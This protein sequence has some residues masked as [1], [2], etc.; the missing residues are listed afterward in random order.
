MGTMSSSARVYN[1]LDQLTLRFND[2]FYTF[3]AEL[4]H[5]MAGKLLLFTR[6]GNGDELV[7]KIMFQPADIEERQ[8]LGVTCTKCC[9]RSTILHGGYVEVMDR[10]DGDLC[11]YIR[12]RTTG[13]DRRLIAGILQSIRH[14][15]TCI[16]RVG[17]VYTDIKCANILYKLHPKESL[18]EVHLGDF[19]SIRSKNRITNMTGVQFTYLLPCLLNQAPKA[20]QSCPNDML[21]EYLLTMLYIDMKILQAML[22]PMYSLQ[23]NTMMNL[24]MLLTTYVYPGCIQTPMWTYIIT[25][26]KATDEEYKS[27]FGNMVGYTA[28]TECHHCIRLGVGSPSPNIRCPPKT[29]T[30]LC[31]TTKPAHP[32]ILYHGEVSNSLYRIERIQNE[33]KATFKRGTIY[34]PI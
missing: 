22:T 6:D 18:L 31:L 10:M 4:G 32:N 9:V 19:D 8:S 7:V 12:N 24:Y 25:Q 29:F 13:L 28:S 5:G 15:L 17:G 34:I 14:Q 2:L 11:H 26:L 33:I 27:I 30:G 3:K 20:T 21:V 16:D 1:T 23:Q